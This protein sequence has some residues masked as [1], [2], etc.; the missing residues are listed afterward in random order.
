L[1][2]RQFGNDD[3]RPFSAGD[4][5]HARTPVIVQDSSPVSPPDSGSRSSGCAG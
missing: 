1:L 4:V 2:T 5:V 3:D